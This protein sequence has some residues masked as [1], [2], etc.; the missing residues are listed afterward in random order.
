[1]EV[2]EVSQRK[3]STVARRVLKDFC[4]AA[5]A[6]SLASLAFRESSLDKRNLDERRR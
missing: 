3:E 5:F 6:D 4:F 1:M 2:R